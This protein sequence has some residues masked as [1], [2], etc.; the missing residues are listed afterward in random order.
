MATQLERH[1]PRDRDSGDVGRSLLDELMTSSQVASLLQM[2]L[3]TV[4]SY[5]RRGVLPS[6]KV[7]RHRRF[8]RSDVERALTALVDESENYQPSESARRRR[9]G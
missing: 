8:V 3:S 6:V 1:P 9:A 5:A 7:G 2:R 4:E